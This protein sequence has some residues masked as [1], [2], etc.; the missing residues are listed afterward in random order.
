MSSIESC[1]HFC[2]DTDEVKES[3]SKE[4]RMGKERRGKRKG[5]SCEG[6][7]GERRE[8]EKKREEKPSP[9]GAT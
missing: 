8:E 6:G 4:T 7:P 2:S 9:S 3:V 1:P 5:R